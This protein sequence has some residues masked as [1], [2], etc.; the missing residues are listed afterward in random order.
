MMKEPMPEFYWVPQ[1][2]KRMMTRCSLAA[3]LAVVL[4]FLVA[5]VPF[6]SAKANEFR[7]I[8]GLT[9]HRLL[10]TLE[11]QFSQ[12]TNKDITP[13]GKTTTRRIQID[14]TE[15]HFQQS[16]NVSTRNGEIQKV[17]RGDFRAPFCNYP[18]TQFINK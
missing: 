1:N 13:I 7:D 4:V 15:K 10:Q 12:R 6:H 2:N 16:K 11:N 3:L 5:W 8:H 18:R 14:E 9:D 17:V